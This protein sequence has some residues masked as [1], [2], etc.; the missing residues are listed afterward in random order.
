M[1]ALGAFA[2]LCY[3]WNESPEQTWARLVVWAENVSRQQPRSTSAPSATASPLPAETATSPS[4]MPSATPPVDPLVWLGAHR[5]QWPAEARLRTAT[6]FPALS[7]GKVVGSLRV[8]PGAAVK[9]LG[10]TQQEVKVDF[11]GAEKELPIA[12]TDLP[13]E[14][15][16]AWQKSKADEKEQA[17]VNL[18]APPVPEATAAPLTETI[19]PAFGVTL[20]PRAATFRLFAPTA[21]SVYLVLYDHAGGSLG[22]RELPLLQKEENTW[23]LEVKEDL[24]G[25][26]YTY[27]LEGPNVDSKKELLDPYATNAV[28]SST[29]GR[30][31][32]L[33]QPLASGPAVQSPTDMVIYE[34]QV[35]DF[36]IA[37]NS[38]AQHRGLYLGWTESGT[39]LP[40]DSRIRTTLDHL[41]ELGVTHL[42]LMP[43]EDFENDES[44]PTYNWGYIT[45]CFFSPEGMFATNPNDDSRIRELRT[46]IAALHARGIGVIMDVVY[47]HTSGS[48]SLLSLAP[49]TY[50]RHWPDGRLANGSGCGNEVQSENP[51]ARQLIIDSLKFWVREYG[52]D[53]FRFD[54][55]ALIDQ[56]TMRQAASELRKLN[57]SIV[58]FGEPWAGGSSPLTN[59]ADKGAVYHLEPIGAFNDDFRNALK[60]LP[61]GGDP[62][63]IQNGSKAGALKE[64]FRVSNW[65]ASPAQSI[66]YMTC[67]DNLVLWDKLKVSMPGANDELLIETMKLGYVALF[68]APGVPFFLGGEE[69]ARSKGGNNNSYETPD[70]VNQ[71]DWSLKR[72]HAALFTYVRD[73]I[74]LRKA[75]PLFRLK[76]RDEVQARLH[77]LDWPEEKQILFTLNGQ[78]LKGES[79]K[80]A[81]VILNSDS[82]T[83][84]VTLPDGKWSIAIDE[85][86]ASKSGPVSGTIQVPRKSG[87]VLYQE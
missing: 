81:C 30:L 55:M 39:H 3:Y 41:S 38:G 24:R 87:M 50:Y 35:R 6:E 86:R 37:P 34:M 64:A 20:T 77:L 5:E 40:D 72:K 69:F 46:L 61:D 79:W 4:A 67:H 74:A 80:G 82:N 12:D 25:K 49:Q 29:R 18:K 83:A 43:V 42:E 60:G 62:G 48:A 10:F 56:D 58:L 78:D 45:S 73:L 44:H 33:P 53:G 59:P 15:E 23:E 2:W 27:R 75:H 9:L 51:I 8:P 32:E 1:L 54:L 28:A 57:P 36:T 76:T 85:C 26:F 31:T 66:N 84:E 71:I 68:T 52:I 14:A 70:S 63:W 11:M 65:F 47:N 19:A 21:H 22:R 7:H 16:L 17:A 13:A